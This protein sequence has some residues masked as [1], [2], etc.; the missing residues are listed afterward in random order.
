MT[1]TLA[2]GFLDLLSDIGGFIGLFTGFSLFSL[3]EVLDLAATGVKK[4]MRLIHQKV[5]NTLSGE[6]SMN[7][8]VATRMVQKENEAINLEH[9]DTLFVQNI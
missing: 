9:R 5:K 7:S 4:R 8:G 1:E 3:V 2:I 6:I